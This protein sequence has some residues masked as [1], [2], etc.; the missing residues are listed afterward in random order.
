MKILLTALLLCALA[1]I[2]ALSQSSRI[3]PNTGL[4]VFPATKPEVAE[5]LPKF[6]LEFPGGPV[7]QFVLH[8]RDAIKQ[9]DENF[10]INIIVPA[11]FE[12]TQLPPLKMRN[13]DV[14]Q[15]FK[16]LELSSQMVIAYDT[17]AFAPG[18]GGGGGRPIQQTASTRYGFTTSG[19]ITRNSIWHFFA[20]EPPSYTQP[21]IVRYF[22]LAPY[23]TQFT[24]DDIG[25]AIEQGL[26]MLTEK[27][28][29]QMN[30]HQDTKLLIAAGPADQLEMINTMLKEL[31]AGLTNTTARAA[32]DGATNDSAQSSFQ[33][34]LNQAVKKN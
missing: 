25:S 31:G 16:A 15:L 10:F 5:E 30:F 18:R 24:M 19:P 29:T 13:I 6:D 27:H 23:L 26:N 7:N 4:P 8:L 20:E 12:K 28:S 14:V 2:P 32:I 1:Q 3:D 21:R 33:N 17:G 11:K 22:Q 9:V 34:R